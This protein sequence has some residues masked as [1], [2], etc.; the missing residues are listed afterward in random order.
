M[1]CSFRQ[2]YQTCLARACVPRLLIGLYPEFGLYL[3]KH[4]LTVWPLT[5]TSAYLVTERCFMMFG[6]QTSPFWAGL[7]ANI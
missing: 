3:I 1:F 4:V 2:Q 7:L 5:S 6:R